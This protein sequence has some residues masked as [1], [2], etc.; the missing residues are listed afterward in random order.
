[1]LSPHRYRYK[2]DT[3]IPAAL[4]FIK[5]SLGPSIICIDLGSD[6]V[7]SIKLNIKF[8]MLYSFNV[9]MPCDTTSNDHIEQGS[10][11]FL[12]QRAMKAKYLEIYFSESHIYILRQN[13][14]K[15][16]YNKHLNLFPP[17]A[18]FSPAR[19]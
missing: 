10:G 18:K 5:N 14:T 4:F 11:T 2:K 6:R 17:S 19:E 15:C 3:V 9:Y 1:M 12:T 16:E 8:G 13:S 7:C